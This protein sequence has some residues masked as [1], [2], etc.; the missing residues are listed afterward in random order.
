[1]TVTF[2]RHRHSACA[3]RIVECHARDQHI[4]SSGFFPAPTPPPVFDLPM[5]RR[6]PPSSI[7]QDRMHADVS[8]IVVRLHFSGERTS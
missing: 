8:L 5:E 7:F 6:S 3:Q 4:N 2:L 1:M